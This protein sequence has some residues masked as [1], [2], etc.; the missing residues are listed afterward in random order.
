MEAIESDDYGSTIKNHSKFWSIIEP[1][2]REKWTLG[3]QKMF[4]GNRETENIEKIVDTCIFNKGL[5]RIVS[6]RDKLIESGVEECM[7]ERMLNL[8]HDPSVKDLETLK[9]SILNVCPEAQELI[10]EIR[11]NWLSHENAQWNVQTVV[12]RYKNL[13][14]SDVEKIL[15]ICW[16]VG[17][18]LV[19]ALSRGDSLRLEGLP[20]NQSRL[21]EPWP[22]RHITKDILMK[23]NS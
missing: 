23:A 5:F 12:E 11:D 7:V 14:R 4:D 15:L 6:I 2:L 10:K 16:Q 17:H 21:P 13:R 22:M 8:K 20:D 19:G 18:V 1:A 3:I 9:K